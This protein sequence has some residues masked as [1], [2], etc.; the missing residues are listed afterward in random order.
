MLFKTDESHINQIFMI[1][2]PKL[3]T[4]SQECHSWA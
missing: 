3:F 2:S 1:G 4:L